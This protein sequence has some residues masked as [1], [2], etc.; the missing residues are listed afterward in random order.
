LL[1]ST[2]FQQDRTELVFIITPHLVKPLPMPNPPLPTDSFT[3]VNEADVYATG[4]ME[5]RGAAKR[6]PPS[7]PVPASAPVTEPSAQRSNA[8]QADP[9]PTPVSQ[10][11]P[12]PAQSVAQAAGNPL[13]P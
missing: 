4:I 13:K 5:G 2:S 1:R 3:Q 7:A 10:A 11:T 8:P 9:V 12:L 6:N